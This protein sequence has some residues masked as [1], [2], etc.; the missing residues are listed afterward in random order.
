[1]RKI[2]LLMAALV[3]TMVAMSQAMSGTYKVGTAEVSPNFTSLSAAVAALNTN[4]VSG[5]VI[6]EI[7]SD[8]TESANI[9]L[10]VNTNGFGIT[11][12]PD[13]DADRTITFTKLADNTSPTGHFVIGYLTTGLDAAWSDANTIGT[14]NVTIDGYA[15][16]GTTK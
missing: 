3:I 7:T 13:A 1:M 4:G 14:S 10:G 11:I 12:R 16:G 15:V 2:T 5:D 6:L 9:G 8:I